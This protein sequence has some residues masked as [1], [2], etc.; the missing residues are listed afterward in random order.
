MIVGFSTTLQKTVIHMELNS[1]S[2]TSIHQKVEISI[3]KAFEQL[4]MQVVVTL[5]CFA[6]AIQS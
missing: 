3:Q 6:I 4:T 1:L 5:T 2:K